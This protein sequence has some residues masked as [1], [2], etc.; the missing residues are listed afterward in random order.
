MATSALTS[1]T[2]PQNT[3]ILNSLSGT[4]QS[5]DIDPVTKARIPK[6]E[7]DQNDF[8]KLLSTQLQFQDP[9]KPMES[10]EFTS[11]LTSFSSLNQ[12]VAINKNI[13][14]MQ[15]DRLAAAQLQATALIG[16]EVKLDGN[17][18]HLGKNGTVNIPFQ[19][20]AD[21]GRVSV[22]IVDKDGNPIRTIEADAT[23]MKAG[24]QQVTWDGKD[25]KGQ[26]AP[27][28]DYTVEVNAFDQKGG[29]IEATTLMKGIVTGVDLSG[30]EVMLSINGVQ[31]PLSKLLA[32]S[33]PPSA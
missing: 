6:K 30:S 24:E 32:V 26:A 27:E 17:Q 1:A 2:Q 21:P 3:G 33:T 5:P 10:Q 9:L 12:L 29:E 22:H 23:A 14:A 11:Q 28:G 31:V 4:P 7:L 19:L 8:L 18:I 13:Q 15:E 25:D 16:K 20:T